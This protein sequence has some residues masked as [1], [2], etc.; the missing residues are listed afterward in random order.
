MTSRERV[1]TAL[2]HREADRVPRDLAGTHVTGISRIAYDN[3][4]AYLGMP[5]HE[6][7]WQD[8][9]QQTVVP[10]DDFLD[11]FGVDTRGLFPLTSHNWNVFDALQDEG[12]VWVYHDEWGMTQH[13][14]KENGL[15]FTIVEH[16]L[17]DKPPEPETIDAYPWPDA[18][19][20]VRIQGLREQAAAFRK[21]G[22]AVMIKGICAGIFEMAQRLRGMENALM[23]PMIYPQFADRLYGTLADLKIAFW[24][25]ALSELGDVVDIIV[26]NDD[27]G[28]QQSQLISFDQ[29]SATIRPHLER[30]F[31]FIKTA[32]PNAYLFFHSCGNV[33]PYLPGFIEAGIDILNP[34]HVT[35]EGMEPLAL[36]RDFGQAIT[37]WGGGV[38]TQHVLP[39]GTPEQ[40]KEDV[41]R[42][43]D[44][45]APGGG[46][47]FNTIHNIQSEV[48]PENL[49][50]MYDA[51]EDYS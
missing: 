39:H 11:R 2:E 48:P 47:V 25:T 26:E 24:E 30:V 13:F 51:L 1:L 23:D 37:F 45:L 40:V 33:R 27:Y 17:A 31:R 36:K 18:G 21:Q 8:V 28:T 22:K 12:E 43:L 35:A 34:V 46:Y 38:D 9:I 7:Q 3:T 19:N 32:A 50:A 15:W 4:R 44:A 29:Y 20:P 41:K 14:P 49:V 5:S 6:P 42:N 10:A 16:P